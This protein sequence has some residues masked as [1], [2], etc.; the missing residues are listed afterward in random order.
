MW[1]AEMQMRTRAKFCEMLGVGGK[2]FRK[3]S[4]RVLSDF[5]GEAGGIE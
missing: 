5:F 2:V 1:C 4:L 3:I